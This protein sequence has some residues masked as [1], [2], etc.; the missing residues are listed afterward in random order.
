MEKI[1]YNMTGISANTSG[2]YNSSLFK[3]ITGSLNI[4][5]QNIS[6]KLPALK[7]DSFESSQPLKKKKNIFSDKKVIIA[8]A[9]IAAIAIVAAIIHKKNIKDIP[10]IAKNA[11]AASNVK[12]PVPDISLKI[13]KA[14]K[15]FID[16]MK[17]LG[18][19]SA[20]SICFYGT[21][22]AQK[23]KLLEGFISKLSEAGYSIERV[24]VMADE[25]VG[26]HSDTIR[27]V[28]NSAAQKFKDTQTRTAVVIKN[29]DLIGQDRVKFPS[30][31]FANSLLEID[32][33]KDKGISVISEAKDIS[34]VDGALKRLGRMEITVGPIN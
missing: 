24:P 1:R 19:P 18:E 4:N 12:A 22:S 29:L 34:V 9:V 11:T 33:F 3:D 27:K 2:I 6:P 21:D 16:D 17:N 31:N 15:M 20:Q 30:G 8:S 10:N 26:K 14:S 7:V 13:E 25:S 5:P 32:K 23:E 28:F